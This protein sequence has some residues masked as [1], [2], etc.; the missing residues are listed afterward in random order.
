VKKSLTSTLTFQLK[1]D[2]EGERLLKEGQLEARRVVNEVFRLDEENYD[3]DKIEDVVQEQSSHVKN[4]TQ[5]LFDKALVALKRHYDENDYGHP[6][7]EYQE[8][9]PIRMNCGEGYKVEIDGDEIEYRV[10]ALKYKHVR[11]TLHGS[12]QHLERLKTAIENDEWRVGTAEVVNKYGKYELHINVTNED[13]EVSDKRDATTFIGVDVNEDCIGLAA[14]KESEVEDSIVIEYPEVKKERHEFFT[15]R[16]R[17]QEAGQFSLESEI[18]GREKQFVHD[19]L[20]QV[21]R[22]VVDWAE[23]FE[24][25][26]IVFEDLKDMRDDIGYGTRMNRRLHSLP[27]AQLQDFVSYKAAWSGIP[28]DKVNP[29]Y[30]SQECPNCGHTSQSNRQGKRFRCVECDWQDHADR[31]AGVLISARG[32]EKQNRNVPALN[33][34]PIIRTRKV[35]RRGNGE[36]EPPDRNP[37]LTIRGYQTNGQTGSVR[38]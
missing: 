11:G 34:L 35:R 14:V 33:N 31:K 21:S 6:R 10:S 9:Y 27:F 8:S 13:A 38:N 1:P 4:T 36:C 15:I 24:N 23:Q 25:P 19:Q 18:Q 37:F 22:R 16:K 28:T 5:R 29:E 32:L 2:E 30:T 26:V 7:Q 17:M 3:W 12:Q 20:H